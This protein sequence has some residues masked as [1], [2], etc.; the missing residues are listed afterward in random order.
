MGQTN[1]LPQLLSQ[2]ELRARI[3]GDLYLSL[4]SFVVHRK[5]YFTE[6]DAQT[7]C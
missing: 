2:L 6:A 7:M 1:W 5:D 3:T 4:D